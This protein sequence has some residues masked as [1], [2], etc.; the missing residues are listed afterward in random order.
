[1][2]DI[3]PSVYLMIHP[4]VRECNIQLF[5][6]KEKEV[7]LQALELMVMFDIKIKLQDEYQGGEFML[8]T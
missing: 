8:Q 6:P 7:F 1:M 3:L 2:L 4:E 5:N